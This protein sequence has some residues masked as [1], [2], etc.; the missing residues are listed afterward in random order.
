M[1]SS[2][3]FLLFTRSF[4]GEIKVQTDEQAASLESQKKSFV[5]FELKLQCLETTNYSGV[6][7]WK[8]TEFRRRLAEAKQ[9]NR[10]SVY[11]QPFFTSRY[12]YRMCARLYLNGD[13]LGANHYVSFFFVI[14]KGEY[15]DVLTWPFKQKVTL[16]LLGHNPNKQREIKDG[17]K[18]DPSSSSFQKPTSLMNL[19]TGCPRFISHQE[20]LREDSDFLK[21]DTI[22]FK[23]IVDISD[24]PT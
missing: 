12:G 16:K 18:P 14:M 20:L 8:I 24:L 13:G 3:Y 11:S 5:D 9:G 4:S 19:A 23:I 21:D 22:F 10:A 7:V 15:D 6:L 2:F 17:F 1:K